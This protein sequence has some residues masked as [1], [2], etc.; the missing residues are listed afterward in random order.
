MQFLDIVL[1]YCRCCRLETEGDQGILPFAPALWRRCPTS[2]TS[3]LILGA[4]LVEICVVR[5]TFSYFQALHVNTCV[6]GSRDLYMCWH[7]GVEQQHTVEFAVF[8]DRASLR[9]KTR[10]LFWCSR[11]SVASLLEPSRMDVRQ[12]DVQHSGR[13]VVH[14]DAPHLFSLAAATV[15]LA[16]NG[17]LFLSCHIHDQIQT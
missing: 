13:R 15:T 12:A 16:R 2:Q 11:R 9:R 6:S 1:G 5:R 8:M 14:T 17:Q 7:T 3:P 4:A 10:S